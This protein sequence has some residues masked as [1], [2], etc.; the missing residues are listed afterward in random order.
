MSI[1]YN[2]LFLIILSAILAVVLVFVVVLFRKQR[3]ILESKVSELESEL[4]KKNDFLQTALENLNKANVNVAVAENQKQNAYEQL[5]TATLRLNEYE[6]A[7]ENSDKLIAAQERELKIVRST[8]EENEVRYQQ[9]RK[10][11]NDDFQILANKVFDSTREKIVIANA[12]RLSAVVNP[13]AENIADFRKRVEYIH[14]TEIRSSEN[15]GVQIKSLA[16]LNTRLSD[17][18]RNLTQALRSNNKIAG[19]W[20]ETILE[21]IFE[22]CGFIKDI[23]YRTQVNFSDTTTQQSRLMPDFIIDLPDNRSIIVDSKLSLIDYADYC[24]SDDAEIKRASLEKFKKSVRSHLKE[25][26]KKY[27]SIDEVASFKL[28]FMPIEPA[29]NLVIEADKT[30][31]S[32]AYRENVLIVSP[33]SV[34]A[35]LK[36][37]QIA[38]RSEAFAKNI[39]ELSKLGRYLYER[40]DR[41]MKTFNAIQDRITQLQKAFDDSK[42]S[43]TDGSQSVANTARRFHDLTLKSLDA[44]TKK[45]ETNSEENE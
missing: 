20:G 5:K 9:M 16:E 38:Y 33:S 6:I 21:R 41:F 29:Y 30:L 11:L 35:I 18:A 10:S 27:N 25:F 3:Q 22:S 7:K 2:S 36:Y 32:D 1:E 8:L 37:A 24:A 43:L 39:G 17:D 42:K 31:L 44:E 4:Q 28:M 13:L 34:M 19:N 45:L 40:I 23:H 12:E 15:I 14:E 26:S